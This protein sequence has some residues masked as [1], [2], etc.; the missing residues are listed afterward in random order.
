MFCI[1]CGKTLD[2][3]VE[4]CPDCGTKVV[5]PEGYEPT[6][7][8][9]TVKMDMEMLVGEKTVSADHSAIARKAAAAANANTVADVPQTAPVAPA[10]P[11][12]Q[13]TVPHSPAGFD[14]KSVKKVM[15]GRSILI[16]DS[17]LPGTVPAYLAP[18]APPA[19]PVQT[20]APS[21]AYDY[22]E[23]RPS[24][25]APMAAPVEAK[26]QP[27]KKI[28]I[29]AAAVL[30]V[31]LV[32]VLLIFAFGKKDDDA[33]KKDK[34]NNITAAPTELRTE[35]TM[36]DK[37]AYEQQQE[38]TEPWEPVTEEYVEEVP[39]NQVVT[40][41]NGEDESET[42][43]L[44][45]SSLSNPTEENS[46]KLFEGIVN[47]LGGNKDETTTDAEIITEETVK[48]DASAEENDSETPVLE[49]DSDGD[50]GNGN[51][52]KPEKGEGKKPGRGNDN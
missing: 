29:A 41:E 37:G 16:D 18:V 5:L 17:P 50:S 2:S 38:E 35:E 49:D 12:A 44:P 3:S 24:A 19:P 34:N 10:A 33:D 13:D 14:L 9:K 25:A 26:K 28:I 39:T 48:G 7:V 1:K 40:G 36:F 47:V 30:C 20:A 32:A 45:D 27:D 4:V 15:N 46:T 8:E 11:V 52:N 23:A 21:M 43:N 6:V 51:N 31:A 42:S 22:M